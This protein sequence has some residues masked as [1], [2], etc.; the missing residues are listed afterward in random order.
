MA[1]YAKYSRSAMGHLTKH[2]ERA[3]NDN[4]DYVRFGN[5]NIDASRTHLNYNLAPHGKSQMDFIHDRLDEVYCMKR[6]DVV[7]MASCVVTVPKDVPKEYEAEFFERA[8]RFLA[9]KHG[10]KNVI[11]A[12][13]HNDE[14]TPHMHFSFIP[15]VYDEKKGRE[16]VCC[17]DVLTKAYLNGFHDELQAEMNRW[18]AEYGNAFG[19]NVLNG[20][21][22]SGNL[23][24]QGLQANSLKELNDRAEAELNGLYEK[25]E[26]VRKRISVSKQLEEYIE[27]LENRVD[28]LEKS[29]ENIVLDKSTLERKF[30][31]LP[32]IQEEFSK[33]QQD[34]E[35]NLENFK[36]SKNPFKRRSKEREL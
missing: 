28:G 19:C 31:E 4:G 5:Q 1:N 7:T 11:S 13:V 27:V 8:Y 9:E 2:Y 33:Y 10:E 15:I 24:I 35:R 25:Q 6:D 16:K 3:K 18:T 29:L 23:H 20:A 34:V 26:A 14:T 22:E 17:K 36:A 21:T 30:L 12:Y 32:H